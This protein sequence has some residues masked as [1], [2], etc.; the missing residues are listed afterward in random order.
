VWKEKDAVKTRNHYLLPVIIAAMLCAPVLGEVLL[1]R[2]GERQSAV[3]PY[4]VLTGI[5]TID[6]VAMT[7][8]CPDP[9]KDAEF[10]KD[11][12]DK[13]IARF[14]ARIRMQPSFRSSRDVVYKIRI[15]ILRTES[16]QN[17]VV[18]VQSSLMRSV[19]LD[20]SLDRREIVDVWVPTPKMQVVSMRDMPDAVSKLV[21]N[22][23]EEF[24]SDYQ[25]AN[26][27]VRLS[28]ANDTT[29]IPAPAMQ[30]SLQQPI[31]KAMAQYKYVASKNSEVFHTPIC[32]SAKRIS[33]ENLVGYNSREEAIAAG[34]KPCK[35]CKP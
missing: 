9:N 32:R 3:R 5:D 8:V 13:V 28:D 6:A 22:Q 23:V 27:R 34:K 31:R 35:L 25:K 20:R 10:W 19:Y 18:G 16:S 2:S 15:E 1:I 17:Y 4:G 30:E 7:V 24:I 14:P 26:P 21:V 29:G 11:L 12:Y 33:P